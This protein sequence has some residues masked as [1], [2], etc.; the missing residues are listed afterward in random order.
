MRNQIFILLFSISSFY[1]FCDDQSLKDQ[2]AYIQLSSVASQRPDLNMGSLITFD[3]IQLIKN[4]E[5]TPKRDGI[6]CKIPGKYLI[7]TS[8]QPATLSRGVS[9]YL[10]NW[11]NVNGTPIASSNVRQYVSENAQLAQV[12]NGILI[13]LKENDIFSSGFIASD[14]LI[15]IV[16][17]Q[18]LLSSEPSVTS[19]I[20]TAYKIR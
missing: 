9:G 1:L 16:F 20:L 13:D 2:D 14:P 19:Y 3:T 15:G 18:S 7:Y 5:T 8:M 12:T 10:D 11:Y 17:I 6:V 4:F